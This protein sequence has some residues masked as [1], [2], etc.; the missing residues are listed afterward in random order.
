MSCMEWTCVGC[1][2]LVMNNEPRYKEKCPICGCNRWNA[3]C[4]ETPNLSNYEETEYKD[5]E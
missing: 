2:R 3:V 5:K 4:D 1:G